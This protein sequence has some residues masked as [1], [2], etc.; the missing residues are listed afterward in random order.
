MECNIINRI[1]T[2]CLVVTCVHVS[3]HV[4]CVVA[5][6]TRD[7]LIPTLPSRQK[8]RTTNFQMYDHLTFH[9]IS[10]ISSSLAFPICMFKVSGEPLNIWKEVAFD[11]EDGQ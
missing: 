8:Y 7:F 2:A 9:L 10:Q 4:Q 11:V 3:V 1:L 6:R 5:G